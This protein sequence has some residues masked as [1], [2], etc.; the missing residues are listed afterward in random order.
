MLAELTVTTDQD[1]RDHCVVVIK[2]TFKTDPRGVLS[3]AEEQ[4]PLIAADEHYGDPETTSVRYEC[5]FVPHKPLTDVIVVGNAVAPK[6]QRVKRLAVA[7][8]VQGKRKDL[9]VHGERRW[10]TTLGALS[11]SDA[12]AFKEL[13]IT[14]DRAWGG[15]DDS[16]GPA[17]VEVEQR[18]LMGKGFHPHRPGAQV[19]GLPVPN[20]EALGDAITSPRERH[21]P[22]G[23][24]C[25]GRAWQP[26]VKL[27][28]TYDDR[29]RDERAPFLPADF[30]ARYFQCAPRDQQF[31]HFRGGEKLRCVHMA[32]QDVVSYVM[33]T[34]DVPVR[35][36]F[37]DGNVERSAVLDTVTLEPHLGLAMLVYRASVPLRKKLTALR[38]IL[39]GPPPP[40]VEPAHEMR[41][42]R[43]GKP[44]F[45]GLAAALRWL[46]QRRGES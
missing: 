38:E 22:A 10:V 18:N 21:E 25:I 15:I 24:G 16:R 41:G 11:P 39:V 20:V 9:A 3:L 26:R 1:A 8:E 35:F 28:G 7:L 45:P 17:K 42:Y 37:T 44:V 23:F 40:V 29:W 5:D 34:L 30:D 32:E 33:P 6:G 4:R 2:G 36:R 13:P 12:V 31:P 27:A 19:A 14:F 43:N 46:R